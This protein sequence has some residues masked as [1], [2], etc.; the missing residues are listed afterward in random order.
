VNFNMWFSRHFFQSRRLSRLLTGLLLMSL[1]SA[2]SL[3]ATGYAH[4]DDYSF[5]KL[6]AYVDMT[7]AQSDL[8]KTAMDRLHAWHRR[9]ELPQYARWLGSID[10]RLTA[11]ADPAVFQAIVDG[12]KQRVQHL[13]L[14]A[15]PDIAVFI[16]TLKPDQLGRI[17][18][19]F[20]HNNEEFKREFLQRPADT[21]QRK[22]ADR[23][24]ERVQYWTGPLDREQ[25]ELVRAWLTNRQV[26]DNLWL[27][28]K[29]ARQQEFMAIIKHA[30]NDKPARVE[31]EK[32]LQGYFG[33]QDYSRDAARQAYFVNQEQRLVEMLINI[34]KICTPEQQQHMHRKIQEWIGDLQQIAVKPT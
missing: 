4:L 18:E 31:L 32:Q 2:C 19:R 24:L 13:A 34:W 9:D 33:R 8:A 1:L 20:A 15:V 30:V 25:K 11:S 14:K 16:S 23:W 29:I 27:D 10:Q 6:K 5:W 3:I 21:V 12:A 7:D 17:N 22:R 26:N 28:E